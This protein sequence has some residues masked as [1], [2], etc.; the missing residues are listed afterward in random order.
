[1]G[2]VLV[3]VAGA[4]ASLAAAPAL[5][6]VRGIGG[7]GTAHRIAAR[8]LVWLA[9]RLG[10]TAIK[11]AQIASSRGDLLPRELVEGLARVQ[12]RADPPRARARRRLIA[13]ALRETGTSLVS[14]DEAPIACGCVAVVFRARTSGGRDVVVKVVRR[15]IEKRIARDLAAC[16]RAIRLLTWLP[17]WREVPVLQM[18]DRLSIDVAGQCDMRREAMVAR[19]LRS[20]L[21]PFVEIPE[22][23]DRA[24]TSRVLV[25]DYAPGAFKISDPAI[26]PHVY[27]AACDALLQALYSMVFVEGLVHC[28]LHPG[29][30]AVTA[31]GRPIVYDFGL[32]SELTPADRRQLET[33]FSALAAGDARAV[34]EI[35]VQVGGTLP[36]SPQGF[37]ADLTALVHRWSGRRAGEFLVAAFVRELFDLQRR[38]GLSGA[39]GFVAAIWALSM[40]E[41]LVR[42]RYRELDFQRA[43]QWAAART[44]LDR[45]TADARW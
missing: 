31:G 10:P 19:R 8:I 34:G 17:R 35:L 20:H 43:A 30:V 7:P 33:L 21:Q 25:M 16:R 29:N 6:V 1:M 32:V 24:T 14:I 44:I 28:D 26:P 15:G 23:D 36:T 40:Y 27:R 39:P 37:D 4:V 22:P 12:D 41:G 11:L 18:F 9:V 42:D 38:H 3:A 13:A 45:I 5:L 2:V